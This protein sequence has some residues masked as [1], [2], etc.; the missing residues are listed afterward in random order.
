[1]I[2]AAFY[3]IITLFLISCGIDK[4]EVKRPVDY[5]NP[6]IGTD[7]FGN[8]FPGPSLPYGMVHVSPDTHNEGWLYRKGYVYTDDNI[9][10]FSHTHGAGSGGEILVM[11][12]VHQELQIFP[13]S[14]D[15]PDSGYRSRF[16][17]KEE[18]ATAG[19]YRVKLL[20]YDV[21]AELTSTQRVAF[22]R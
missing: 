17:H 4:Q 3:F 8:V 18:E 15:D 1:M 22:H 16:S 14:K 6:F 11:P 21:N 10:G 7:F 5:V 20:D 12:T 19:Y 13:G 2:R 9:I